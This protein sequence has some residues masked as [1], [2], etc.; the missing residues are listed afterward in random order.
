[1]SEALSGQFLGQEPAP[2][3]AF[4]AGRVCSEKGC[5]TKLSIYN[6]SDVCAHHPKSVV[7]LRPRPRP[8]DLSR[9]FV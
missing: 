9:I 6:P 7:R 5:S 2:S 4:G 3:R 1:M 8:L